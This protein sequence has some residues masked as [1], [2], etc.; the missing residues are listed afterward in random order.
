M[1]QNKSQTYWHD[2]I[3][4]FASDKSRLQS[5]IRFRDED[6]SA[7]S[8]SIA[9]ALDVPVAKIDWLV[10]QQNRFSNPTTYVANIKIT[11]DIDLGGSA[12]WDFLPG[13]Y[14]LTLS[15]QLDYR[16]AVWALTGA[17]LM[18]LEEQA[19][20]EIT[21]DMLGIE[22]GRH[23]WNRNNDWQ[24]I[25]D[26]ISGI[27]DLTAWEIRQVQDGGEMTVY[28]GNLPMLFHRHNCSY[29]SPLMLTTLPSEA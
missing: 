26:V 7:I 20:I 5:A 8:D 24:I 17:I 21:P 19:S 12:D 10:P 15:R 25:Q 29:G 3:T 9:S 23:D 1:T 27:F 28:F 16:Q 4:L 6:W 18:A 14:I 13:T 22:A 2:T 11:L